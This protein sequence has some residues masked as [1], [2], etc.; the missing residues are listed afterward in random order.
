VGWMKHP[1]GPWDELA[2]LL[3]LL[4]FGSQCAIE[5]GP[6]DGWVVGI[7]VRAVDAMMRTKGRSASADS[8]V[9]CTRWEGE[10]R[11]GCVGCM[12]GWTSCAET[13]EERRDG[14][15]SVHAG[16]LFPPDCRRPEDSLPRTNTGEQ[17]F[18]VPFLLYG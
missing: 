16:H 10:E 5:M 2:L 9:R 11:C 4:Q 1:I 15:N 13:R 18:C 12:Y 7:T 3:L 17:P 6:H 14:H 8:A